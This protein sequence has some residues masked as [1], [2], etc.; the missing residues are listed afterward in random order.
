[1]HSIR[2]K[3]LDI[4]CA[5]AWLVTPFVLWLGHAPVPRATALAGI[6]KTGEPSYLSADGRYL[7]TVKKHFIDT[8][9]FTFTF[10]P[11]YEKPVDAPQTISIWDI[12]TGTKRFEQ[13]E[14]NASQIIFSPDAKRVVVVWIENLVRVWDTMTSEVR[15]LSHP[16]FSFD[17]ATLSPD[18]HVMAVAGSVGM[19]GFPNNSFHGNE[20]NLTNDQFRFWNLTSM[21]EIMVIDRQPDGPF[22]VSMTFSPDGRQLAIE[23]ARPNRVQLLDW[24]KKGPGIVLK[25]LPSLPGELVFA[26]DGKTLAV[27]TRGSGDLALIDIVSQ[28]VRANWKVGSEVEA[29]AYSPDSKLIAASAVGVESNLRELVKRIDS[30]LADR[31]CPLESRTLLLNAQSGRRLASLP[32]S[33]F[34]AFRPDGKTLITY[35]KEQ[36]AVFLWDV[37]PRARTSL[38]ARFLSLLLPITLTAIWWRARRTRH[39]R[40]P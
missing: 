13:K 6:S 27:Q 35:S 5:L 37:P 38:F 9:T 3:C 8:G 1:M 23:V 17:R 19:Q 21:K 2:Y 24:A 26:P 14:P 39:K 25:Y 11:N 10:P 18:G 22:D 29:I 34:L 16:N 4:L 33:S 15:V 36:D 12:D 28:Q 20:I 31:F 30:R 32:A 7:A 40:V